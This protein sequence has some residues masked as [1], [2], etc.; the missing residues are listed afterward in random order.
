MTATISTD[1]DIELPSVAFNW[2]DGDEALIDFSAGWT[3]TFTVYRDTSV[4]LTKTSG[5]TGAAT[6]PNVVVDWSVG[7]LANLSGHYLCR[8]VA[9]R[10]SDSKDRKYPDQIALVVGPAPT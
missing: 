2:Y 7:E 3:F 8:L 6:A 10:T 4:V 1:S 9:R 5:I